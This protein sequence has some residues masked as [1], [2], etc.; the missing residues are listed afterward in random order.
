MLRSLKG[1][2]LFITGS[3][4]GIGRAIALKAAK[5]GANIVIAA[6]TST[7]H[8]KLLG[9]IYDAAL[10]VEKAGGRALPCQ[11]D[12]RFEDQVQS[13]AK[14]AVETFGGIDILINNASALNPTG[15]LDTEMKRYDLMMAVNT[16][17]TFVCSKTCIPYLKKAPNPHVLTLSPPPSLDSRWFAP[18]VAYTISKFGMSLLALGMS[19]EF[20]GDGIA[21]NCLWPKT[22]IATAAVQYMLG[23]EESLRRSRK[24][25]IMADAALA[26]LNRDSRVC[27][28]NFFVD[29][30][31]LKEEGVN[32]F[33]CY[34]LD[35]S[36]P[37]EELIPDFF[38]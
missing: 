2:T 34:Q 30:D 1:K 33:S 8:S 25:E 26:V 28:G 38:L 23:G 36:L 15:T 29:E 9:T 37:E 4:R 14:K 5:D 27:T 19:E 16:R 3:S 12:I 6:K 20:K 31:V 7:P 35:P 17:G 21:F 32:D 22:M 10:E 24:P 11:V 13:A 18:H